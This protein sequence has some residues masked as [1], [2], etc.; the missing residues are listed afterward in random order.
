MVANP[1]RPARS[2]AFRHTATV[3]LLL[4]A[5][6]GAA[7]ARAL[8]VN[9]FFSGHS[10][11]DAT[12]A[13]LQWRATLDFPYYGSQ[14]RLDID[15]I[16]GIV[17]DGGI[18]SR[19]DPGVWDADND[20][21]APLVG[22]Y[23][24][25]AGGLVTY[26]SPAPNVFAVTWVDLPSQ[27]DFSVRNTFQVVFVGAGGYHTNAGLAIPA[28]SV[29]YAYGAPTDPHGTVHYSSVTGAAIGTFT[30]GQLVTVAALG[31]GDSLGL[32]SPADTLALQQSGDPFLFSANGGS[33][34]APVAFQSIP[35]LGGTAGVSSASLAALRLAAAPN[36]A[37]DGTSIA[38]AV[39]R[40]AHVRMSVLDV[41]GR[42]VAS[43]LDENVPAGAHDLPW[44][45]R[46][47][48]GDRLAPGVYLVQLDADGT[49][50]TKRVVVMP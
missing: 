50:V 5:L 49:R 27:N 8:V 15:P 7:P 20:V 48:H 11:I 31:V 34:D 42:T 9:P 28:G 33:Y 19:F 4:A 35:E 36:P 32:L 10:V 37:R 25:Y 18:S 40:P 1:P 16:H 26:G 45:A 3:G 22:K 2:A 21:W 12:T 17:D 14:T 43:L 47:S 23:D 30:S 13:E 38:Y 44:A 24:I 6:L 46:T 29:V 39:P 41:Q